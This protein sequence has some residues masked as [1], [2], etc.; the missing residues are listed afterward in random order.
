[1]PNQLRILSGKDGRHSI[2][3]CLPE[4]NMKFMMAKN[5]AV[6]N[7][8]IVAIFIKNPISDW[9]KTKIEIVPIDKK[10]IQNQYIFL[11]DFLVSKSKAFVIALGEAS[12]VVMV[13]LNMVVKAAA[14]I[15]I[16]ISCPKLLV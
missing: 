7:D 9:K 3:V 15:K 5:G 11:Y 13:V 2:G 10:M 1:M 4:I 6:K 16:Y 8:R 14:A 12:N